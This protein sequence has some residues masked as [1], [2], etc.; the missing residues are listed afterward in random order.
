MDVVVVEKSKHRIVFD[1]YKMP[2]KWC[3]ALTSVL[4]YDVP[5]LKIHL[6]SVHAQTNTV[7]DYQ[8]WSNELGHIP[9]DSRRAGE[10]NYVK[11]CGCESGGACCQTILQLNVHNPSDEKELPVYSDDLI[12]NDPRVL[13]VHRTFSVRAATSNAD[14]LLMVETD[15]PHSFDDG[16][17]VT[18]LDDCEALRFA[19]RKDTNGQLV[20]CVLRCRRVVDA[21][22]LILEPLGFHGHTELPRLSSGGVVTFESNGGKMLAH[23]TKRQLIYYLGPKETVSISATVRKGTGRQ[24]VY[25]TSVAGNCSY[26]PLFRDLYLNDA[27]VVPKERKQE[28]V[29]VCPKRVFDIEDDRVFIAR[30]DDCDACRRCERW[31]E[32]KNLVGVVRLPKKKLADWHRFTVQTNGSIDATD[33][34]MQAMTIIRERLSGRSDAAGEQLMYPSLSGSNKK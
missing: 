10:F 2:P 24:Y 18:V 13:P 4:T 16:D 6:V 3:V 32:S 21:T 14:G 5:T 27:A 23:I 28:L 29:D 7:R 8:Q 9:I 26:R 22:K 17:V 30:P 34:V 15:Q 20:F 1:V 11:E 25:W 19:T 12:T 31:A 33:A